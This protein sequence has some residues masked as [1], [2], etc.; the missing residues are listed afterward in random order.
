MN[1]MKMELIW[2]NCKTCPPSE[3]YNEDLLLWDGEQLDH[4]EYDDG[5]WFVDHHYADITGVEESC[6]WADLNQTTTEFF[7]KIK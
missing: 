1:K 7:R 4:A 6:W 5:E 2:H 3:K